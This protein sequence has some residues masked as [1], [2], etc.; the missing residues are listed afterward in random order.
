MRK[1]GRLALRIMRLL[2]V[3]EPTRSRGGL[4]FPVRGL[5]VR[6]I[7]FNLDADDVG[8]YISLCAMRKRGL[9]HRHRRLKG[10]TARKNGRGAGNSVPFKHWLGALGKRAVRE[11]ST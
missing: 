9:V 4:W 2:D 7:A 5:T 11:F 8:I 10:S 6:E 1:P 3:Q